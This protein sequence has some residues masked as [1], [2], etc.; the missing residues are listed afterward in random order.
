VGEGTFDFKSLCCEME[1]RGLEPVVVLEH[2]SME[3]T[4]RSLLNFQQIILEK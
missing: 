1:A 3:E 4:T 2:H